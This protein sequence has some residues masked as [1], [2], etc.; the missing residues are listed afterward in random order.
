MLSTER[1]TDAV[2]KLVDFGCAEVADIDGDYG[3]VSGRG[4][5]LTSAYRPPESLVKGSQVDP[6]IDMWAL[7][8]ILYIMLCGVHPFDL[9]GDAPDD[10]VERRIKK[11]DFP[12][13]R[14]LPRS[15]PLA[16]RRARGRSLL[17]HHPTSL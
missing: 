14:G 4:A 2:V 12:L 7:G 6:R 11:G 5:G 8:V 17:G 15:R 3:S 13:R 1:E 16:S 10:V 9:S